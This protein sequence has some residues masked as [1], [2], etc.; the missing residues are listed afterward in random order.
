MG[1]IDNTDTYMYMY[2]NCA[3]K[4]DNFIKFVRLRANF[5]TLPL[6]FPYDIICFYLRLLSAFPIRGRHTGFSISSCF[7]LLYPP[8]SLQP[9]PCPLSFT[10][11]INILFG[12]PRLLFP[13]NAILSIFLPIYIPIIFPPYMSIPP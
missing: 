3:I 9:Q 7:Y 12:L 8:P 13:D 10:T 5:C 1:H 2:I 6:T 11:S 4:H